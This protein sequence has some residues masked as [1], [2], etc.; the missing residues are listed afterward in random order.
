MIRSLA[1]ISGEGRTLFFSIDA[2]LDGT[3]LD[4]NVKVTSQLHLMLRL[5]LR[6]A[7]PPL[8]SASSGTL[9]LYHTFSNRLQFYLVLI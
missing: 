1:S 6:G 2:S 5:R 3:G 8:C 4:W 9:C 7:I